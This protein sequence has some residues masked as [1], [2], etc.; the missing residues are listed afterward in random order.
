MRETAVINP[1]RRRFLATAKIAGAATVVALLGT[2]ATDTP[3]V[4]QA[5]SEVDVAT[6]GRYHETEHIRKYYRSAGLL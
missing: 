4:P 5:S 3:S 2:K 6:P 1:Q